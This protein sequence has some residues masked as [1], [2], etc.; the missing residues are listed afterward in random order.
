MHS[1]R[2]SYKSKAHKS[3]SAVTLNKHVCQNKAQMNQQSV[4]QLQG[5]KADRLVMS[6]TCKK[7]STL[8]P[9]GGNT[10]S[11][12]GRCSIKSL[13]TTVSLAVSLPLSLLLANLC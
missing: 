5:V 1:G 3:Q 8:F 6:G 10:S 9:G 13:S 12:P 7:T 4:A 11:A 2:I